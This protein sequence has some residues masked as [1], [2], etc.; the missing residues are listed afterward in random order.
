MEFKMPTKGTFRK[1]LCDE[2][3]DTGT[4]HRRNAEGREYVGR[5]ACEKGKSLP[6]LYAP[7]D[8]DKTRP[9]ALPEVREKAPDV[10]ERIAGE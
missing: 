1:D 10:R 7:S 4:I 5:C 9:V 6:P 2:C 3:A 8:K